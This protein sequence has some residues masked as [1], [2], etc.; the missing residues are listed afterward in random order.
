MM[1][2]V[3]HGVFLKYQSTSPCKVS[4]FIGHAF[5]NKTNTLAPL[6]GF[7][8]VWKC[9]QITSKPD[10]SPISNNNIAAENKQHKAY[11]P[12]AKGI[13]AEEIKNITL[14]T[15]TIRSLN[16]ESNHVGAE[17]AKT[18][19][20]NTSITLL[21]LKRNGI[22]AEGAKA[23]SHNTTIKSLNLDSN[24][25]G[26][27]GAMALSCNTTITSLDLHNNG[28]GDEGAKLC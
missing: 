11:D 24:N 21:N 9:K 18:L 19:A 16:L 12:P 3:V 26:D 27:E 2:D 22:R 28:I 5:D 23:L 13:G 10:P 15:T 6:H 8:I 14:G 25:I 17:G 1:Q 7:I 20:H 4:L